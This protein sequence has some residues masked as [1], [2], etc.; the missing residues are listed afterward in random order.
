MNILN[1]SFSRRVTQYC[2]FKDLN[3]VYSTN[4]T[5]IQYVLVILKRMLEN[6]V[7]MNKLYA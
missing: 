4:G 2:V 3:H 6:L 7:E 1:A 5:F